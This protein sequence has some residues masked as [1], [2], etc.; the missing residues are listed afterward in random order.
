MLRFYNKKKPFFFVV[1]SDNGEGASHSS[2]CQ[3]NHDDD[4][5]D[6][7]ASLRVQMHSVLR[8]LPTEKFFRSMRP[9]ARTSRSA[10]DTASAAVADADRDAAPNAASRSAAA[11]IGCGANDDDV[12]ASANARCGGGDS[13]EPFLYVHDRVSSFAPALQRDLVP[14]A[15]A[16]RS[17][18]SRR[19][20]EQEQQHREEGS[21][22]AVDGTAWICGG[23]LERMRGWGAAGAQCNGSDYLLLLLLFHFFF[24][25]I[26]PPM[27][28]HVYDIFLAFLHHPQCGWAVA[29]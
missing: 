29:A 23:I 27:C 16:S 28:W 4:D 20:Q 19:Q 14:P 18:S 5:D 11:K 3:N 17:A 6:D 21:D 13:Q 24:F 1:G 2:A 9:N 25:F 7:D 26:A 8:D 22:A 15:A 10:P 12:P